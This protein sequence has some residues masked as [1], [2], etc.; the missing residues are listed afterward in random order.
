MFPAN[1]KL[2]YVTLKCLNVQKRPISLLVLITDIFT[3]TT[4]QFG[5]CRPIINRFI[6]DSYRLC[7]TRKKRLI[8]RPDALGLENCHF[9]FKKAK[10]MKIT[11]LFCFN[12]PV[13]LV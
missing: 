12:S 1:Q 5:E 2:V 10:Y 3:Y 8:F 13:V 9:L 6:D 11:V 4:V 7:H